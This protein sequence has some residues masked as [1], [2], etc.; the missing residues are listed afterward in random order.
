[1]GF[2]QD[3]G[4][5][6][7][8]SFLTLD[9]LVFGQE[10]F[11]ESLSQL[12]LTGRSAVGSVVVG[13]NVAARGFQIGVQAG[14]KTA[15]VTA[16][17]FEGLVPGAGTLREVA[18]RI[19]GR[20]TAA[21]EEA[22]RLAAYGVELFRGGDAVPANPVTGEPWLAMSVPREMGWGTLAAETALGPF[23]RIAALPLTL[24]IDSLRA[25][26]ASRAGEATRDAAVKAVDA[27]LNVLPGAG[28]STKLDTAELREL[29]AALASSS[30][31]AAA[32]DAAGFVAAAAH[33]AAGDTRRL[34]RAI[35]EGIEK[36]RL[37]ADQ[38]EMDEILPALPVAKL[39][40]ERAREIVDHP[41]KKLLAALAQD[42]LLD[43][44]GA[45]FS[46]LVDEFDAIRTF[47]VNY[48]LVLTLLGTN[49]GVLL[50]AGLFDVDDIEEFV[51]SDGAGAKADD[52]PWSAA[53][54]ETFVAQAASA[55]GDDPDAVAGFF[56]EPTVRL[57]QDVVF[58]YSSEVLGRDEA[59]ARI[60]QLFGDDARERIEVDP[61]LDGEIMKA[62]RGEARDRKIRERIAAIDGVDELRD[63][64]DRCVAQRTSLEGFAGA[65]WTYRPQVIEERIEAVATFLSLVGQQ[66]ALRDQPEAGEIA[67]HEAR[68]RFDAW[69]EEI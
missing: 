2:I 4:G 5:K 66:L 16:A 15:K 44:F 7:A 22:S 23:G 33:L 50:A 18:E 41:P 54:L 49:G 64:R 68:R 3:V 20:S 34:G 53:D 63:Q 30:G 26:A 19:D 8:Q 65:P 62:E 61:S 36:M 45:I 37:L 47:S 32:R 56:T 38:A 58:T 11:S 51:R 59:L 21:A 48:P 31:E 27:T 13:S 67:R 69:A 55:D 17:A 28:G 42:G 24:G 60:E 40:R 57:A 14:A 12:G 25:V 1:M 46:A 35:E 9:D 43:R 6:L 39:V 10:L 52:E 29:L